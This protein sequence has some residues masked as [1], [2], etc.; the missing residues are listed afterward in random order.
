MQRELSIA[1]RRRS[2]F[3]DI[4]ALVEHL[5]GAS[6]L[7]EGSVLVYV[8][9]TTAGVT[10]NEHADPDVA[11]DILEALERMVPWSGDYAHG[12]GNAAAHIKAGL[13]G[14]SVVVPVT[15]GR[16]SLGA[17]QGIFFAEFDGPRARRVIVS[18]AEGGGRRDETAE[19]SPG[20]GRQPR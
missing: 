15:G 5:V 13:M 2:E 10:I 11:R 12:E 18:L 16:M 7:V 9:H 6:G 20:S 14:S 3:I 1:S 19:R 17:W 8:P 4:T